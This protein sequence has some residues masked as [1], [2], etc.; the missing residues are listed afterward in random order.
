MR[1]VKAAVILG[2]AAGSLACVL[3]LSGCAAA[4]GGL[5]GTP[6]GTGSPGSSSSTVGA[7]QSITGGW[8]LVSGTDASGSIAPSGA[9]LTLKIDGQA[10]GG[11]GGCTAFGAVATGATAGAFSLR[12][13]AGSQLACANVQRSL[14]QRNYLAALRKIDT[15][16]MKGAQLVLTGPGVSLTFDRQAA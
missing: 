12:F 14:I 2:A 7:S 13:G 10:S 3:A 16:S 6:A 9:P 8:S 15:A 4:G 1:S 5:G 11:N